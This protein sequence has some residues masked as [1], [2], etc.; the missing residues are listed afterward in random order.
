[1]KRLQQIITHKGWRTAAS[2]VGAFTAS[3]AVMLHLGTAQSFRDSLASGYNLASLGFFVLVLF[4][5]HHAFLPWE[6]KRGKRIILVLSLLFGL[7]EVLGNCLHSANSLAPLFTN[8][9]QWT[10]T[11]T[12][13]AGYSYL[14]AVLSTL[15]FRWLSK[16]KTAVTSLESPTH[17]AEPKPTLSPR[18]CF[19]VTWA[20]VFVAYVPYF[21]ALFPGVSSYDS[22]WQ[23]QQALGLAPYTDH[24]PIVHTLLIRF[25]V[26]GTMS[27]GGD[28][29]AG[30]AVFSLVQMLFLSAV[31]A[32]AIYKM[33]RWDFDRRLVLAAGLFFALF[34]INAIYSV[35]MW[36]NIPFGGAMLLLVIVLI[37]LLR[38]KQ[39]FFNSAFNWVKFI[40]TFLAVVFMRNDGIYIALIALI[41]LLITLKPLRVTLLAAS[42]ICIIAFVGTKGVIFSA[43]DVEAG[44]MR[45]AFSV[46]LQQFARVAKE[47]GDEL[48]DSEKDYLCKLNQAE[49]TDELAE[50]YNP[51]ISDPVKWYFDAPYLV[52]HIGTFVKVW[53][54]LAVRY[55]GT[56]VAAFLNNNYGYWTV[57]ESRWDYWMAFTSVEPNDFG[58]Q[59]HS[60]FPAFEKFIYNHNLANYN[61]TPVYSQAYSLGLAFWLLMLCAAALVWRKRRQDLP[62]LMPLFLLWLTCCASPV[63]GEYRYM[64]GIIIALP[65]VIGYTLN[66]INSAGRN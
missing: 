33:R 19:L 63:H 31:F 56:Y 66:Q 55:P 17:E 47:H 20:L 57:T 24:H 43:L 2:L 26:K 44:P 42:L 25:F 36:K 65:V 41:I 50:R 53:T 13:F 34:P 1:V 10:K 3:L 30:V 38:Q 28:V 5:A 49:S 35:T 32:Y 9:E 22:R 7:A 45:E 15:L 46:P 21:L 37:D 18:R 40:G 64:Y 4:A 39:R 52:N 6:D 29:N 11:L 54:S 16:P 12:A 23:L 59:R 60:L 27:L 48:S 51:T 8:G 14:F 58:M 61:S 62:A